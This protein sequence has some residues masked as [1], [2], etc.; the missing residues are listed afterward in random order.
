MNPAI[1]V[2]LAENHK[3]RS[4][5]ASAI[6][7]MVTLAGEIAQDPEAAKDPDLRENMSH[8]L[9]ELL[10]S[11]RIDKTSWPHVRQLMLYDEYLEGRKLNETITEQDLTR[12]GLTE[13]NF[14]R[15]EAY[16]D[17]YERVK[18]AERKMNE[19]GGTNTKICSC[20]RTPKPLSAF[21]KGAVCNTCR[22]RQYRQR[23]TGT[24]E[25]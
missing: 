24:K 1:A 13:H 15:I 2:I 14:K 16:F 12:P 7:H 6:S 20:C 4:L 23:K 19:L 8:M 9:S 17:H 25:E 3:A 21:K 18:E 5:F 11:V 22:S 10:T